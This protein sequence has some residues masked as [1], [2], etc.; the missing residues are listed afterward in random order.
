MYISGCCTHSLTLRAPSLSTR[1]NEGPARTRV[2]HVDDADRGRGGRRGGERERE[3]EREGW[4]HPRKCHGVYLLACCAPRGHNAQEGSHL[5]GTYAVNSPLSPPPS[6]LTMGVRAE[7][8]GRVHPHK[9]AV[10]DLLALRPRR[11]QR[12]KAHDR[13]SQAS[14]CTVN[15][16][17]LAPEQIR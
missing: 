3:R 5:D 17:P 2:P 6:L 13:F 12:E 8:G 4:I 11:T 16:P 7:G 10:V 15:T 14:T 1:P 9:S